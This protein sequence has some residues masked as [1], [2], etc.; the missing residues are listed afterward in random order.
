MRPATAEPLLALTAGPFKA[1]ATCLADDLAGRG[2]DALAV[3]QAR[4]RVGA[5]RAAEEQDVWLRAV[6]GVVHPAAALLHAQAPPLAL[7]E[8]AALGRVLCNVLGQDDVAADT[9]GAR[10]KKVGWRQP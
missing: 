1:C 4:G 9:G 5:L 10:G 7:G 2:V 6:D 8:Q 3:H